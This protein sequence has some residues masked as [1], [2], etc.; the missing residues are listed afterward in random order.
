MGCLQSK[1]ELS[2]NDK[3]IDLNRKY[4][5]GED[6]FIIKMDNC[7]Y[8]S[9]KSSINEDPISPNN[10]PILQINT[11]SKPNLR[12]KIPD[13]NII[14]KRTKYRYSDDESYNLICN[15]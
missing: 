1:N 9:P 8:G 4:L 2:I 7:S 12:I 13:D 6:K 5:K 3:S 15:F 11:Y 14:N 10:T